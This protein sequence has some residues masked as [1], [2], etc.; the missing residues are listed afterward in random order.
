M[1]KNSNKL[2]TREDD[3]HLLELKAVGKSSDMIA[4][5]LRRSTGAIISRISLL[6]TRTAGLRREP[7]V[8]VS[9]NFVAEE[10]N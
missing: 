6:N 10:Q 5:A 4:L 3:R 8:E 2:W 1:P 9:G 7:E